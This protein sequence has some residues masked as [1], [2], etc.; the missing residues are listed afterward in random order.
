MIVD[1]EVGVGVVVGAAV[2]VCVGETTS[3]AG[4]SK[5]EP[6][7]SRFTANPMPQARTTK[8]RIRPKIAKMER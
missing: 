7:R 8:K 4:A 1:V 5:F 2:G 3:P 6:E